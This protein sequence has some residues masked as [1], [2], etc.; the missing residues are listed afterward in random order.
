VTASCNL[1]WPG[2]LCCKMYLKVECVEDCLTDEEENLGTHERFPPEFQHGRPCGWHRAV[3]AL[4]VVLG[5]AA[6][7]VAL[8]LPARRAGSDGMDRVNTQG[9][10]ELQNSPAVT[11]TVAQNSATA[12]SKVQRSSTT[13]PHF[14]PAKPRF[15][16]RTTVVRSYTLSGVAK[17][18]R[19]EAEK[20]NPV[21][22]EHKALKSI[23]HM[24]GNFMSTDS[25]PP[26][27]LT[28]PVPASLLSGVDARLPLHS[29]LAPPE[30]LRDGNKCARDEEEF[31]P[32]G[33]TCYKKCSD[34]TAGYFPIRNSPFSC[35]EAEPCRLSNTKIHL[36]FCSGFDVAGDR[37]GLGCPNFEGACLTDEELFAGLCY[38]KCSLFPDA[39][40]PQAYDHRVAPNLCCRT[41]GLLCLLPKYLKFNAGFAIGGGE[42]DGNAET[43]ALPHP[44]LKALT[45][46]DA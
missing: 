24:L 8:G 39:Q 13:P 14:L 26:T 1:A 36:N 18:F 41:R 9:M 16:D 3:G 29:P 27:K 30:A 45:E 6:A 28:T 31:P 4:S 38:K 32:F 23:A 25:K 17:E 34:L 40:A 21:S 10:V 15:P 42:H 11:T 19:E 46:I 7:C 5:A 33:G 43:P 12:M 35:C 20:L 22:M 37:E 44:P 2:C